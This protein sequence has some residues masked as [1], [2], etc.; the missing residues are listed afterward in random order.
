M[1]KLTLGWA[2]PIPGAPRAM[3]IS[4]WQGSDM[5]AMREGRGVVP[6]VCRAPMGGGRWMA[7]L[8][9]SQVSEWASVCL[10]EHSALG[11]L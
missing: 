5:G 8:C 11:E 2:S 4:E 10:R 3:C 7:G 1:I 9:P 6:S